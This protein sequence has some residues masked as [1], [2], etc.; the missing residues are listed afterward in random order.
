MKNSGKLNDEV[1]ELYQLPLAEFT[2]ARNALAARLKQS[3]R[4][5][6]AN[7]VKTLQKPPVSAW[8]VNQLYWN[9]REDFDTLLA[10]GKRFHKASLAGKTADLRASLDARREALA[11]LA[12]LATSLLSDAGHNPSLETIR[13]VTTTLEALSA[14]ASSIDGPTLG[15]LSQDVDPP[16]FESLASFMPGAGLLKGSAASARGSTSQKSSATD[17]QQKAREARR[18]EESRQAGIAAAKLALQTAKRLLA[19]ARAAAQNLEGAQKKV[20]AEAKDAEKRKR[21][22]EERYKIASA[23]YEEAA[24][25]ARS[26]GDEASEA[27]N[28]VEEAKRR[29]EKAT[30]ELESLF[31]ES[32]K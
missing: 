8:A 26:A 17:S 2:G 3:G 1:D 10:A 14:Q 18:R 29:V 21:E 11:H 13:R 12:D 16:G 27:A 7:L 25:R 15:R 32:G 28:A 23:A 4:A 31:R 20:L 19:D 24:K 30:K 9:H 22:A 5:D 6:D